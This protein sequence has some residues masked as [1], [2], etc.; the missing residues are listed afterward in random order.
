MAR[1]TSRRIALVLAILALHAPAVSAGGFVHAVES[2]F[3]PSP[4]APAASGPD[5][6]A[7]EPMAQN[8]PKTT[9]KTIVNDLL[10]VTDVAK[11]PKTQPSARDAKSAAE[12]QDIMRRI[13]E[14]DGEVVLLHGGLVDGGDSAA[15]TAV[16]AGLGSEQGMVFCHL[17]P[18]TN[19]RVSQLAS[20][21]HALDAGDDKAYFHGGYRVWD[22]GDDFEDVD[23]VAVFD[24]VN[25][26]W[27]C[28]G[29]SCL[30]APEEPTKKA[31]WVD[32]L[33]KKPANDDQSKDSK[34]SKDS[35]SVGTKK[36][37]S[38]KLGVEPVGG[39]T[40][41]DLS[42]WYDSQD[43]IEVKPIPKG[44][45][46]PA[47]RL[48]A[49]AE[50]ES[51]LSGKTLNELNEW[52]ESQDNIDVSRVAKDGYMPKPVR[53]LLA[54]AR[55]DKEEAESTEKEESKP[56][57]TT[58][59]HSSGVGKKEE[60]THHSS[61]HHSS[62]HH[63]EHSEHSTHHSSH[64]STHSEKKEKKETK[65]EREERE[66]KERE[67]AA[68]IEAELHPVEQ[69]YPGKRDEH[70]AV[71]TPKPITL[72]DNSKKKQKALIVFGGRDENDGRLDTMYA[73]GLE[74]RRWR[75]IKYSPPKPVDSSPESKKSSKKS[76]SGEKSDEKT[77]KSQSAPEQG[78]LGLPDVI[79]QAHE[80]GSLFPLARS[81]ATAVV[82]DDNVMYLF[83]GFVVEGRLGFN[84]GELLAFDLE[85]REFFYPK[86]TGDLPVRRNKHTSVVD[87]KKRMWVWGGS[88]W[89][90]T[91]GSSAYASTATHYADL[92]DPRHV[93][94][95]KVDTKGFPPSQRR[96]HAA[97]HKNGVMYI[98][99]GEDY[100]SKEFL[101]DVHAL[102]LNTF[103]WSQP[104]VAGAAGGGRI[105]AAAVG[106]KLG[107]PSGALVR[108]GEGTPV[109][110][111]TGELQP[112]DDKAVTE[113]KEK[114][115][116]PKTD[117]KSEKT[118]QSEA[119]EEPK[120]DHSKKS[121]AKEEP[122]ADH[123]KKSN[124]AKEEHG[125]DKSSSPEASS[126][127][128]ETGE[129]EVKHKEA[130]LG[131]E[132]VDHRAIA[133]GWMPRGN[134][135]VESQTLWSVDR[136]SESRVLSIASSLAK[137]NI[138]GVPKP[139]VHAALGKSHHKDEKDDEKKDDEKEEEE[140]KDQGLDYGGDDDGP[141]D[142]F[143]N[144]VRPMSPPTED[145]PDY[146]ED[147]GDDEDEKHHHKHHHKH[148]KSDDDD[149]DD[150]DTPDPIMPWG[151][152]GEEK[153]KSDK[154]AA[155]GAAPGEATETATDVHVETDV[156][157][158]A[159]LGARDPMA[160][161]AEA[162][163]EA[164]A[165]RAVKM[166]AIEGLMR[167]S[168]SA[169]SVKTAA[170]GV[171]PEEDA[172]ADIAETG[173]E[174]EVASGIAS[175]GMR[176][177]P[178]EKASGVGRAKTA[179]GVAVIVAAVGAFGVVA[180]VGAVTRLAGSDRG[181]AAERIP[182]VLGR[183]A[184]G[185]VTVDVDKLVDATPLAPKSPGDA[186][187]EATWQKRAARRWRTHHLGSAGSDD[188]SDDWADVV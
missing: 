95:T 60:D 185:G 99:G 82:T 163:R 98:I 103:A 97:V 76:A 23:E 158:E 110:A 61:S 178:E 186:I 125:S 150:E 157:S 151:F 59:E 38:A 12:T 31:D 136:D 17:A 39:L 40:L 96:L 142:P 74:D 6:P 46:M 87:D 90:H 113:A 83:G 41:D 47:P 126:K 35:E 53:Q 166:S 114:R 118:V 36:P 147:A 108:C 117:A 26:K 172:D 143:G 177:T 43:D 92:S 144:P 34:D 20:P 88:V 62:S 57:E 5:A 156:H 119:K 107:N 181:T 174:T 152:D 65:K 9:E 145:P 49:K 137:L 25:S 56:E 19:A 165:A 100:K 171:A 13:R 21:G 111:I 101:G 130:A 182:L 94:W 155:L 71:I 180:V 81:G 148:H 3:A 173:T 159:S 45:L 132:G 2:W 58:A 33:E 135:L 146:A 11:P 124:S 140:K 169:G 86:V 122:N 44:G 167:G 141:A 85:T 72:D 42:R 168:G 32:E 67:H 69:V 106:V 187:E 153:K 161:L 70:V 123:S 22:H 134:V 64:R 78:P 127:S 68:A 66:E 129:K 27:E 63:S 80:D 188:A 164:A 149:D 179:L 30:Q 131:V 50:S 73:L 184:S 154:K 7:V 139:V 18:P 54:K 10:D 89:D 170:L 15:D 28:A 104:H 16:L 115:P 102:D 1:H 8:L 79:A 37:A 176:V 105:R 55:E 77:E 162:Q 29:E 48:G 128:A 138:P 133:A 109:P 175:L 183:A 160:L 121:E 91:G 51:E 75:E 120:A 112:K 24:G 116:E 84:V 52:Y 14:T 4:E 93:K